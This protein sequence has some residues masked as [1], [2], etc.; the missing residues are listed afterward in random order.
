[1]NADS[2]ISCERCQDL[3]TELVCDELPAAEAASLRAHAKGC[4]RCGPALSK[5][6]RTLEVSLALPLLTP[7]PDVERRIMQAARS[8]LQ[9]RAK[10]P[11]REAPEAPPSGFLAWCARVG[12]WAMSPQVAMASVLLL[13]VGIGLYALPLGTDQEAGGLRASEDS[14]SPPMAPE[15]AA[16]VTAAPTPE[17][18]A[19]D[20][21]DRLSPP[22]EQAE[23]RKLSVPLRRERP[24]D[25]LQLE[26]KKGGGARLYEG[27]NQAPAKPKA[28]PAPIAKSADDG[29]ADFAGLGSA[30]EAS[31]RVKREAEP[32]GPAATRAAARKQNLELDSEYATGSRFA[33]PPPAAAPAASAPSARAAGG[34]QQSLG[35]RAP[36]ANAELQVQDKERS[37]SQAQ[38]AGD[39]KA[40]SGLG[41]GIAAAQRGDLATAQKLLAPIAQQGAQPERAQASLWLARSLRAAGDCTRALVYYKPLADAAGASRAVLEEAADCYERTGGGA[42]AKRLR[43]RAMPSAAPATK[44]E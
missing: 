24:S 6:E 11:L 27:K 2:H 29:N 20:E 32:A 30:G 38:G 18:A 39:A 33:P 12:S 34:S 8:A 16:T 17:P 3:L 37:A 15:P 42:Q 26:A 35:G 22:R 21:L 10:G 13:V 4:E 7:S 19:A 23:E 9:S 43:A 44:A 31:A 36:A 14:S 25:G 41:Q 5:F 28:A 40:A 1:V